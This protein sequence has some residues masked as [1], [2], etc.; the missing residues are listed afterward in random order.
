MNIL[1]LVVFSLVFGYFIA[2]LGEKAKSL[3][4]LFAALE[5][6]IMRMVETVIW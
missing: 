3:A 6:V 2:H 4:G 1:G 5:A